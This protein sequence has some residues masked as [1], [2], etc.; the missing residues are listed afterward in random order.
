M[1]SELGSKVEHKVKDFDLLHDQL[2]KLPHQNTISQGK[3]NTI[4]QWY[5]NLG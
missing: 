2:N 4:D 1:M 3:M 5:H